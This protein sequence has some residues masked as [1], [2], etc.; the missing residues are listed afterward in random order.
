VIVPK[1]HAVGLTD[2]SAKTAMGAVEY[3]SVAR[4]TNMVSALEKTQR[5]WSLDLRGGPDRGYRALG[6]R[7]SWTYLSGA[8]E[9]GGGSTSSRR[10]DLRRPAVDPHGRE[11]LLAE[12]GG[13]RSRALLRSGSPKRVQTRKVLDLRV[14]HE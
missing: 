8:R 6:R 5:I 3:V 11:G 9:R 13:G 1:H 2:A 10:Q 14:M 12:R 7:P 4:Q